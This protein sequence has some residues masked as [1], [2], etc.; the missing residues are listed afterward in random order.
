M[1][2]VEEFIL[3]MYHTISCGY[4]DCQ[5]DPTFGFLIDMPPQKK[6]NFED[7]E[8]KTACA[9]DLCHLKTILLL[10]ASVPEAFSLSQCF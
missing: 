7:L 2:G 3:G 6:V 8:S 4:N 9:F 1:G 10:E 5:I